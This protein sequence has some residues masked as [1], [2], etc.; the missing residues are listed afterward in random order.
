M[1]GRVRD[2][3]GNFIE[4]VSEQTIAA[5]IA[6]AL[7]NTDDSALLA[8]VQA[9]ITE[10]LANTATDTDLAA[11]VS[12]AVAEALDGVATDVEL[13]A[14]IE[15]ALDQIE[16]GDTFVTNV[17]ETTIYQTSVT[18][19]ITSKKGQA[20]E[21]ATLDA[22]SKLVNSQMPNGSISFVIDGG[23]S[24][25]TAGVKGDIEI[26]FACTLTGYR[27]LADQAGSAVIDIWK[28]T[29]ANFPPTD[30]DSICAGVEPTLSAAAKAEDLA[31]TDWS[32]EAIAA[33]SILRFNVDSA[34]TVTR[35]TLVLLYTR[36]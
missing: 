35:L 34:A 27:I 30:A 5:Q 32:G 23:G 10:A 16:P 33:G 4:P 6:E 18:Q 7:Q 12:L 28:D 25:I 31:I 9:S 3:F 15:A 14:A 13:M 8:A 19:V 24:A 29:Y 21:L 2:T 36:T 1:V 22:N 17:T 26:P 11:S 20:N